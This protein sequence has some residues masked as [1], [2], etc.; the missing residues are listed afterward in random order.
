MHQYAN[1]TA[2][3]VTAG[4]VVG[5]HGDLDPVFLRLLGHAVLPYP[6]IHG[7]AYPPIADIGRAGWRNAGSSI[8]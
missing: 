7:P 6:P 2:S 8:A 3:R 1:R 4:L 5:G